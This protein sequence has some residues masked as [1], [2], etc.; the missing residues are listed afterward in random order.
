MFIGK[1]KLIKGFPSSQIICPS[2]ISS[3]LELAIKYV[4]STQKANAEISLEVSRWPFGLHAIL[5][6]LP[7]S[8][9]NDGG[10]SP[11]ALR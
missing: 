3:P 9:G 1:V 7:P 5:L 4:K 8:K 11:N 6:Y 2:K 10:L